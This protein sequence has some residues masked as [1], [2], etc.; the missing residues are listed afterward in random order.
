MEK[1]VLDREQVGV[2]GIARLS[3]VGPGGHRPV[4][5]CKDAGVLGGGQQQDQQPREQRPQAKRQAAR[6][7][8]DEVPD[9]DKDEP[10]F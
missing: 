2:G 7:P 1:V 3:L 8:T 5:V 6:P 10:A 4:A 9:F